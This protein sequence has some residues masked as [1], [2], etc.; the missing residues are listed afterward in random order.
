MRTR[1]FRARREKRQRGEK[2]GRVL[3]VESNW[4][5]FKR[6]LE[7]PET[8]AIRQRQ[9]GQSS[10]LAPK[11]QAQTDGKKPSNCSG[12]RGEPFWNKREDSVPKFPW[13][14][15]VRI[16]HVIF[17]TLSVC[18][19]YKS[20]SGSTYGEKCRFRHIKAEGKLPTRSRIKVV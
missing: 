17:G 15:S 10:S 11:A 6:R 9:E 1:N 3:S 5:V 12:L 4:T 8:D 14:N 16:R 20:E 7:H 19:T 18:L 2:S 13:E